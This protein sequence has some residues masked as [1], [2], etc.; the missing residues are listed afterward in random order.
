MRL[1]ELFS[2]P[3]AKKHTVTDRL[4]DM[5]IDFLTPLVAHKVP[6]ITVQ[7]I[8]DELRRR[9]PG[10]LVDRALVMSLLDPETIKSVKDIDGDR[11]NLQQPESIEHAV[12]DDGAQAE[13]DKIKDMAKSK[14]QK[15]V[16][17]PA[18]APTVNPGAV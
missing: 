2:D 7:Q 16:T 10:I 9:R 4:R 6:F 15:D 17:A 18:A 12:D 8:V 13:V 11:I 14:A 3:P 5:A 1:N